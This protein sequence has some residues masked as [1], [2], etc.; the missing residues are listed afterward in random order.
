MLVRMVTPMEVGPVLQGTIALK[1]PEPPILPPLMDR[2]LALPVIF[3]LALNLNGLHN[4]FLQDLTAQ[5]APPNRHP[6]RKVVLQ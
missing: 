5:L 6:V 1:V 3:I 2:S 4:N